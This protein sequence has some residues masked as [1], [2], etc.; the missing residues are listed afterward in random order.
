MKMVETNVSACQL[1]G[2]A[3]RSVRL[4][5]LHV[6]PELLGVMMIFIHPRRKQNL[7]KAAQQN[8]K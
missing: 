1:P 6:C 3:L 5:K 2:S 7:A 4:F 8:R